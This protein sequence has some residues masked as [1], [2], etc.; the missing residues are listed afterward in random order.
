ML[1]NGTIKK[2]LAMVDLDGTLIDT[3]EANYY[4]YKLALNEQGIEI[5]REQYKRYCDGYS[6]KK[7]LP[8]IMGRDCNIEML[9]NRKT[10]LYTSCLQYAHVNKHLVTILRAI[11]NEYYIALVTTASKKNVQ[12]IIEF[13]MLGDLFDIIVTQEDM[14][15]CKPEPDCYVHTRLKFNVTIEN[16]IIFEDS[17]A[18][19]RAAIGSGCD[20]YRLMK[21]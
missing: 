4:A 6:Y 1:T 20:V 13:F 18:G 2:R 15:R 19:M 10:E 8:Q 9:H 21:N 5:T 12:N 14:T 16:T 7:F 17:E 11:K 3:L